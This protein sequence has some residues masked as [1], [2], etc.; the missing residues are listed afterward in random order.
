[1]SDVDHDPQNPPEVRVRVR[2]GDRVRADQRLRVEVNPGDGARVEIAPPLP[3]GARDVSVNFANE[4]DRFLLVT[5]VR[6]VRG[7]TRQ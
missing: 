4:S 1:M 2:T 6:L 3:R 5:G 7:P